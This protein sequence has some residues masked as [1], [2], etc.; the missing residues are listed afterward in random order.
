MGTGGEEGGREG[1][2]LS[3]D[4]VYKKHLMYLAEQEEI[5]R[6]LLKY[7]LQFLQQN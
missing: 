5:R 3:S 6:K 4:V 7:V 1:I 2:V